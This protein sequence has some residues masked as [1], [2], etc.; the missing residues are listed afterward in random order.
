VDTGGG[1][2]FYLEIPA[3]APGFVASAITWG[4]GRQHKELMTKVPYIST[5]IWFLRDRGHGRVS[6]DE[7]GNSVITYPLSDETDQQSFHRATAEAVRI[8]GASGAQEV[9]VCLPHG[10]GLWRRG[11]DL[12]TYIRSVMRLPLLDGAQPIIS[13]HQLSSCPMGPDPTTS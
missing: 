6:I 9:L 8:Q 5:F 10:Q 3:F 2:G 11:E 12:E 4:G 1:F 13:A 7:D